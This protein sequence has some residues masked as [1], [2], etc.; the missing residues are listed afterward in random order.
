MKAKFLGYLCDRSKFYNSLGILG[1]ATLN[2]NTFG[3]RTD[4]FKT[5]FFHFAFLIGKIK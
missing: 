2:L 4:K 3:T 1:V 5:H